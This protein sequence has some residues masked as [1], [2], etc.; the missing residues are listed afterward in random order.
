MKY[1]FA[2]TV[3]ALL[4]YF[5]NKI[6]INSDTYAI[7]IIIFYN[8]VAGFKSV[9]MK[10]I[11][12]LVIIP[13]LL[14]F[15]TCSSTGGNPDDGKKTTVTEGTVVFITGEMFRKLI[16]DY[17]KDPKTFSYLGKLPCIVDFYADWC[18]PCKM[19]APIM[20]DL[21][22]EYKG[23]IIIYKM[24]T[25]AERELSSIFNIRSIPAILLVPKTGNPTMSVGL[26]PKEEY[27]KAIRDVLKVQ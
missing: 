20:E 17:Q 12:F 16:W 1:L 26:S 13:V 24:N 27:V 18:R 3:M 25:D 7:Y 11:A 10:K 15:N 21:A 23:K 5:R 14:V 6:K 2:Q 22:K 4:K 8:F 19:V 9:I